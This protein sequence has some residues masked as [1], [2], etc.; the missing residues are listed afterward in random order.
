MLTFLCIANQESVSYLFIICHHGVRLNT[1]LTEIPE[2]LFCHRK[3]VQNYI[4]K[5]QNNIENLKNGK[6]PERQ[7]SLTT[8]LEIYMNRYES[9]QLC[10]IS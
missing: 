8:G 7:L 1:S 4:K 6:I 10:Y 9:I 5:K 2:R 3:E